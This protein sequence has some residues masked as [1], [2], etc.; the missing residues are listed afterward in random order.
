LLACKL[1]DASSIKKP[2]DQIRG[3][4]HF[5]HTRAAKFNEDDGG[6]FDNLF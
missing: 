1:N 3:T 5:L 6:V 4:K 2:E